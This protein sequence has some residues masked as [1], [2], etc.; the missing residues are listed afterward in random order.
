MA[1][2]KSDLLQLLANAKKYP[3]MENP[4]SV[5]CYGLALKAM[6]NLSPFHFL[7]YENLFPY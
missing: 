1:K 3:D 5:E 4:K 6:N 2:E 7:F